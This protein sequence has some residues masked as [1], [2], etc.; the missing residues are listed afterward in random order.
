MINRLGLAQLKDGQWPGRFFYD[1]P[2]K[3]ISCPMAEREF[4]ATSIRFPDN[5][6]PILSPGRRRYDLSEV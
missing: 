2:E 4:I 3:M 6:E 5:V 1:L